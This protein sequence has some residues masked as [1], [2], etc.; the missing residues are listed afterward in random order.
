MKY[1]SV[2]TDINN[3]INKYR[4]TQI[5]LTEKFRITNIDTASSSEYIGFKWPAS[6][7]RIWK[8]KKS[9]F[10]VEKPGKY[11]LGQVI[12]VN[13]MSYECHVEITYPDKME[14]KEHFSSAVFSPKCIILIM[15][16]S[17]KLGLENILKNMWLVLIK[18]IKVTK[19]K[20]R[21]RNCH[22]PEETRETWKPNAMWYL[23]LDPKKER[24]H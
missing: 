6:K 5:F 10:R 7:N 2:H 14:W 18:A 11:Y 13:M 4:M 15:K 24:D 9:N 22:K 1:T 19:N 17:S 20:V 16:N 23:G 21:L 8:E 12:K 3:W